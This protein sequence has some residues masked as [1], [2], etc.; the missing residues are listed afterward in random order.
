[1]IGRILKRLLLFFNVVVVVGLL[2]AYLAGFINPVNT[3][4]FS[5]F[6][7]AYPYFVIFNGLFV[8]IWLLLRKKL[9]LISLVTL[10]IGIKTLINSFQFLP[11]G[12][13]FSV[14]GPKIN[15]LSYNVHVFD[16][17]H[18]KNN[19]QIRDSIFKFIRKEDPDIACFQEYFDSRR[20]Y[21]PVHDSLMQHQR[22]KYSHLF[23][24]DKIGEF[25]SFG[26]AT[27]STYPIVNKGIV[28][29]PNSS[30][31]AIYSDIKIHEDTIRVFNCHLE[32]IRFL[33]QD[34]NFIDSIAY[35]RS[36]NQTKGAGG[37][38]IRL[39][40]AFRKRAIQAQM[41]KQ[42]INKSPHRVFLCGDF[43]DP[44]S[45]YTYH[46]LKYGLNDSFVDKGLGKGA[47]F[48]RSLF[49]YR[50]DYI[51]FDSG[52]YCDDFRVEKVDYSDHFPVLGRYVI[53]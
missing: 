16:L 23:Y 4:V 53:P 38:Y 27:Y 29:F 40:K 28:Q 33:P 32:S 30:N 44:P 48:S 19:K 24:T 20:H 47:T 9:F 45:S 52:I 34:Y 25:Q 22:F 5:L 39:T 3:T 49:S 11:N 2:F 42:Y 41:L 46:H 17:Y 31:V 37:V 15:I 36:S 50:I 18:W 43:N 14:K 10:L 12:N 1:M 8:I 51:L 7:L 6:G 13:E 35:Q 26:I 21:F